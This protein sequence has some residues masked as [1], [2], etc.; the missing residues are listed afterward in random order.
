MTTTQALIALRAHPVS[1]CHC[2]VAFQRNIIGPHER[3]CDP[4]ARER[5]RIRYRDY[6]REV[7]ARATFVRPA[8]R[9][10][11]CACGRTKTIRAERCR[12]CS[13]PPRQEITPAAERFWPKVDQSG[14]LWACWP[15]TGALGSNG[16]GRFN[17]G[18]RRIV[19]ATR[20]MWELTN[21]PI[22]DDLHVLH[23]CDNPPCVNPAHLWLG[24]HAD[25]MH[26][27]A[28]KGRSRWGKR[29]EHLD[30][31]DVALFF[32]EVSSSPR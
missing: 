7:R 27:M 2:G 16:Y 12:L 21:G 28:L 26:D 23:T 17:R 10:D 15:W 30:E 20:L 9:R 22:P 19:S 4:A 14:G 3:A 24:T 6:A 18:N 29:A 25:N 8:N 1:C 31:V 13:A 32:A 5:R 11:N